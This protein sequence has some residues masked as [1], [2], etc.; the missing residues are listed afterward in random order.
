KE[1]EPLPATVA[2]VLGAKS[3]TGE[4]RV[5]GCS[6]IVKP[7]SLEA[8]EAIRKNGRL[9]GYLE[10]GAPPGYLLIKS[11]SNPHNFVRRCQE[12]GFTV[13]TL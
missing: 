13:K 11:N 6:A 7:E 10:A 1:L 3:T 9:K 8:I 4:V 2:N 12:S 5:R